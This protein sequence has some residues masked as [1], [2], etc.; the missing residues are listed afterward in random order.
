MHDLDRYQEAA[1]LHQQNLTD[2]ELILGPDHPHTLTSRNN[3]AR[4][5]AR[6]DR[7]GFWGGIRRRR[8]E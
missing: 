8:H 4:T 6:L 5:A 2:R 3:F 1:D 7:G